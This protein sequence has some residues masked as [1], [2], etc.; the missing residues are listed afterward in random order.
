VK[1]KLSSELFRFPPTKLLLG[2]YGYRLK[3]I[4]VME[5]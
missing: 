4:A 3:H 5:E 1:A 2:L